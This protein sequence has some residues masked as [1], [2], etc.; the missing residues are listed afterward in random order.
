MKMSI[1]DNK[2]I[3][4][5]NKNKKNKIIIMKEKINMKIEEMIEMIDIIEE[6][7]DM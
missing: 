6:M 1:K 5:K 2:K 7:I 4:L 3:I